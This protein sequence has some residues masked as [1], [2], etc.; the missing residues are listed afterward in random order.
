MPKQSRKQTQAA[1]V[2]EA[3]MG[4]IESTSNKFVDAGF[5]STGFRNVDY[6]GKFLNAA[7]AGV[8]AYHQTEEYQ[9]TLRK[10]KTDALNH[11]TTWANEAF[12]RAREEEVPADKLGEWIANEM[13]SAVG[14]LDDGVD[15]SIA[16]AYKETFTNSVNQKLM[17]FANKEYARNWV[18]TKSQ[19]T[20]AFITAIADND[21]TWTD[22]QTINPTTMTNSERAD[23]FL[24]GK[25]QKISNMSFEF[26]DDMDAY[27]D[28]YAVAEGDI[29]AMVNASGTNLK[30]WLE[31]RN[32]GSIQEA[33]TTHMKDYMGVDASPQEIFEAEI[34]SVMEAEGTD[35]VGKLVNLNSTESAAWAK[36]VKNARAKVKGELLYRDAQKVVM[37]GGSI[38]QYLDRALTGV[39]S[40]DTILKERVK[41]FEQ[42]FISSTYLAIQ[43]TTNI[44]EKEGLLNM[45]D[46]YLTL[47]P[48]RGKKS[49]LPLVNQLAVQF[50]QT[51]N[52][53]NP[54]SFMEFMGVV[55]ENIF[56][57]NT[58]SVLRQQMTEAMGENFRTALVL[59]R[60]GVEGSVVQ[61]YARGDFEKVDKGLFNEVTGTT[62]NEAFAG[63]KELAKKHA[64]WAGP[65]EQTKMIE[66]ALLFDYN[67]Q[68]LDGDSFFEAFGGTMSTRAAYA[69]ESMGAGPSNTLWLNTIKQANI[70]FWGMEWKSG[71]MP[72]IPNTGGWKSVLEIESKSPGYTQGLMNFMIANEPFVNQQ[73][74]DALDVELIEK[75]YNPADPNSETYMTFDWDEGVIDDLK[76]IQV[77]RNGENEWQILITNDEWVTGDELKVNLDNDRVYKAIEE[78]D[79]H[80]AMKNGE[81]QKYRAWKRA[82]G[83]R[84]QGEKFMN[85]MTFDRPAAMA[86]Q[87]RWQQEKEFGQKLSEKYKRDQEEI[88]ARDNAVFDEMDLFNGAMP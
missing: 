14:E 33:V 37:S 30:T 32:Y 3:N 17:A 88:E 5:V 24:K 7:N 69:D 9:D 2:A 47:N 8:K 62:Y 41:K 20:N 80:L 53:T 13:T 15:T 51:A 21:V 48:E 50:N 19:D 35:G 67:R 6:A 76:P 59:Y 54:Q 63:Y 56:N 73:I 60:S 81:D 68:G 12:N 87:K 28:F 65:K 46:M 74:A 77:V 38:S 11:S 43:G 84:F 52:D 22:A 44:G 64:P 55:S 83:Y 1:A 70:E 86:E 49:V 85:W 16:R 66:A 26:A 82:N 75:K 40:E 18:E 23:A 39:D 72:K 36:T 25:S 58:G 78:M 79:L 27:A 45:M 4:T 42:E 57:T 61:Q 34:A 31:S 29:K 71:N 10:N